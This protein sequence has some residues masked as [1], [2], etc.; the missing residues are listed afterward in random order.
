MFEENI[1]Y[2]TAVPCA[3]FAIKEYGNI[4]GEKNLKK[5]F[6]K[7]QQFSEYLI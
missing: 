4:H 6:K 2:Q 3:I 5:V 7:L 1:I